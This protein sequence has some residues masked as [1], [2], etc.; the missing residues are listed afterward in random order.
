MG[1]TSRGKDTAKGANRS[2]IVLGDFNY[3]KICRQNFWGAD[4]VTMSGELDELL[5]QGPGRFVASISV[6]WGHCTGICPPEIGLMLK[7]TGGAAA[8]PN[9]H[10]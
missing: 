3:F 8:G 7:L 1:N 6:P 9:V 2:L 10:T 4:G 5:L